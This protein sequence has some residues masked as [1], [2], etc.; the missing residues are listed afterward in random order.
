MSFSSG[1]VSF[2]RFKVD[3]D[4]PAVVD[5]TVLGTLKDHAFREAAVGVPDVVEAGFITG[6]HLF[7]T[8]FTYEG[9]AFGDPPGS[10]LLCALRLDTHQVPAEVSYA[11][12]QLEEQAAAKLNPSGFASKAQK[13]DAK[14]IAERRLHDEIAEGKYRR[15]KVAPVLWDLPG[16][17][18]FLG[19]TSNVAVEQI[20][21]MMGEAFNVDLQLLT[22]GASASAFF[23]G[24][25]RDFEDLKPSPFTA[26][27][28]DARASTDEA[29][30]KPGDLS[31]PRTP[32]VAG[33]ANTRDFLGNEW[34]IWLWWQVENEGGVVAIGDLAGG[35]RTGRQ[36]R[37]AL[38]IDR[39]LDMECAWEVTGKQSLRGGRPTLLPEAGEALAEGKWPRKMG[40]I[41]ADADDETQWEL[42]LQGDRFAVSGAALPKIEDATSPREIAD[43]RLQATVRLAGVLDGLFHAFLAERTGKGWASRR[44]AIRDWIKA[45]LKRGR[46]S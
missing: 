13:A 1:R 14:D 5:E 27:P 46:R 44:E 9:N 45:R 42:T 3:G 12:R 37:I 43:A 35:K 28:K 39:T 6:N 41:V 2:C 7:D 22:S 38:V 31:I 33:S 26:P 4:A 30:G 19:A 10:L 29:E 21:R 8:Q 40:L 18:L 23:G 16:G 25:R 32:W 36:S 24:N 15:S 20:S 17:Q 34:L 11:Y